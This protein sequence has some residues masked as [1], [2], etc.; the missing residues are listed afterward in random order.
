M[1]VGDTVHIDTDNEEWGRVA[2]DGTILE[3]GE[4][5]ALVNAASIRANIL[6]PLSD[7]SETGGGGPG[8]AEAALL[9]MDIGRIAA[10]LRGKEGVMDIGRIVAG[11]RARAGETEGAPQEQPTKCGRCGGELEPGGRCTNSEC[12]PHPQ[13]ADPAFWPWRQ[14]PP[15]YSRPRAGHRAAAYSEL[16][17]VRRAKQA[18][19]RGGEWVECGSCGGWHP[20]DWFGDCRDDEM[21]LPLDPQ[22]VLDS[23]TAEELAALG[24]PGPAPRLRPPRPTFRRGPLGP[25]G[26]AGGIGRIAAELLRAAAGTPSSDSAGRCQ[27]PACL[28]LAKPGA[29]A[30]PPSSDGIGAGRCQCPACLALAKP[31]PRHRPA[32]CSRCGGGLEPGGRCTNPDC[33]LSQRADPSAWPWRRNPPTASRR[34][35]RQRTRDEVL[36]MIYRALRDSVHYNSDWISS[37]EMGTGVDGQAQ[38]ALTTGTGDGRQ[39][40]VLDAESILGADS[41][42]DTEG[43]APREPG[44]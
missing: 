39:E 33:Q 35:A 21:R 10:G 41:G 38:I 4:K 36:R 37:A 23:A 19:E 16:E 15:G 12:R 44:L 30:E 11:L 27:C 14:D 31:C 5:D 18:V 24:S 32:E 2:S 6:V 28:A 13:R 26:S 8:E 20:A 25:A 7:I 34:T 43:P 40:W 29:A 22:S 17:V 42:S 1:K 9:D 3:I